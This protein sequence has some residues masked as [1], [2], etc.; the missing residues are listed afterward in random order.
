MVSG[1]DYV[2]FELFAI[3]LAAKVLGVLVSRV[4]VPTIIGEISAGLILGNTF[5]KDFVFPATSAEV[6][7]LFAELGVIFLIFEVGLETPLSELRKVGRLGTLVALSGV[8]VPFAAGYALGVYN[9]LSQVESLFLGAALVATSVGITA[10]V[11]GN[12]GIIG[13]RESRVIM[14]AAVIDDV[15]GLA[16]LTVVQSVAVGG[17][18]SVFS[19]GLAIMAS[20]GFVLVFA[21]FGERLVNR[22]IQKA[23]GWVGKEPSMRMVRGA[24]IAACLGLSALAATFGL[25]AIIGA[26]LAGMAFAGLRESYQL[27]H[28][29]V[30]LKEFLAPFFFVFVGAQVQLGAVSGSAFFIA[31]VVVVA[32]ATKLVACYVAS[33]SLGARSALFVGVGM[34]PRGEVGIIVALIALGI[35]GVSRDLY[36]AVVVMSL[37]TTLVTPFL[38]TRLARGLPRDESHIAPSF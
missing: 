25:A 29:F 21:L 4:H 15:L 35:P 3:F 18:A 10:A 16:V 12:L 27:D 37:L 11:L 36:S 14:A 26:F 33:M 32:I 2:I 6:L 5:L 19:A 23:P 34:I 13:R 1:S 7:R 30:S 20:L 31:S 28:A 17:G 8:A 9:T 38:L 22:A 24:A